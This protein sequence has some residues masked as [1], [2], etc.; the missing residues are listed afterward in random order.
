MRRTVAASPPPAITN[1]TSHGAARDDDLPGSRLRVG[2]L[3]VARRI[4]Q[5]VPTTLTPSQQSMVVMVDRFGSMSV[6]ELAAR[7]A[8][9]PPS[10]TRT[11]HA[12]ERAEMPTRSGPGLG[13]R[14][15]EVA[16]TD[17]GGAAA[18]EIHARRDAWLT[19]R[20]DH[21]TAPELAALQAA[22]RVIEPLLDE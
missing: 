5:D 13:S 16:L 19:E 3:R 12:L 22:I 11:V 2:I 15:V 18:R 10:V 8:V 1:A 6:G 20:M 17:L 21:L 14:R 7:E 9:R 4:R